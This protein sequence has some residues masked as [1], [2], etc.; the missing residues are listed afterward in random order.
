MLEIIH[1]LADDG[2]RVDLWRRVGIALT[3]CT[4]FRPVYDSQLNKELRKRFSELT[5]DLPLFWIGDDKEGKGSWTSSERWTAQLQTWAQKLPAFK[6]QA[7][8]E[9]NREKLNR[10]FQENKRKEEQHL[11]NLQK[12]IDD[13]KRQREETRSQSRYSDYTPR[14]TSGG[15]G[16]CFS[17]SVQ[18]DVQGRGSVALRDVH[19]GDMVA[20]VDGYAEVVA[21]MHY[22]TDVRDAEAILIVFQGGQLEVTPDHFVFVNREKYGKL[23]VPARLVRLGDSVYIG[24]NSSEAR[25]T[26]VVPTTMHGY[27]LPLTTSGHLLVNG[28]SASCYGEVGYLPHSFIHAVM[29]FIRSTVWP[30]WM[31]PKTDAEWAM[32]AHVAKDH[33][34]VVV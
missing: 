26:E 5:F 2:N 4:R 14:Y 34:S 30:R 22:D 15:G 17:M 21:W 6:F 8:S 28:M 32:W 25:V 13:L 12:Q 23:A 20:T 18:T 31:R 29:T 16:G 10:Q 7:P 24:Q 3:Q 1:T 27:M 33:F 11:K 9:T 19:V